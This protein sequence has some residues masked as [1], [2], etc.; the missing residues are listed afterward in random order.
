MGASGSGKSTLLNLI[1][2][3]DSP[4]TGEY[5]LNGKRV[6]FESSDDKLSEIRN[7]KIGFVFQ[8][9]NL[10][11]H[12]NTIDNVILPLQYNNSLNLTKSEMVDKGMFYLEKVGLSK[13]S[14]HK[15]L[16]LSG[17]QKQRVSIARALVNEPKVILA[18]EPTGALDSKTSLQIMDLL[19]RL[20]T[21]GNTIVMVTH[22]NNIADFSKRKIKLVDGKLDSNQNGIN[23]E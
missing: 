1:G 21:E 6:S 10:I 11:N 3:L 19:K 8:S 14:K 4:D 7:S 5:K 2:L 12:K 13:W 16:Q 9:F 18:D 20:N 23:D 15:P 17:G 22:D